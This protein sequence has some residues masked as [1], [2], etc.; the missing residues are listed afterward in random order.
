[1]PKFIFIL[2]LFLSSLHSFSQSGLSNTTT[3][4]SNFLGE[5]VKIKKEKIEVLTIKDLNETRV[6][7]LFKDNLC[8][9][10]SIK[11]SEL[12]NES[13]LKKFKANV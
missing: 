4:K 9:I 1:M 6:E 11:A 12:L 2:F 7:L 3:D 13:L 5:S 8:E 10:L